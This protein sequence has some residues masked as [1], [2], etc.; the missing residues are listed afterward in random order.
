MS[1]TSLEMWIIREDVQWW[2]VKPRKCENWSYLKKPNK[3]ASEAISEKMLIIFRPSGRRQRQVCSVSNRALGLRS[4]TSYLLAVEEAERACL[5]GR[6]AFL[7]LNSSPWVKPAFSSG[8]ISSSR[9][10]DPTLSDRPLTILSENSFRLFS[11][12]C[13]LQSSR[14]V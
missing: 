7:C 2:K 8:S 11:L 1:I 6:W 3:R 13:R 5:A 10:K 14:W 9:F 12:R 4:K